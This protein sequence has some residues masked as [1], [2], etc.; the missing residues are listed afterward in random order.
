MFLSWLAE[1]GL[2]KQDP[3]KGN[4]FAPLLPEQ[5]RRQPVPQIYLLA[6]WANQTVERPHV[7]GRLVPR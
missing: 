6:L 2:L 3:L 4:L 5:L 7:A 1:L